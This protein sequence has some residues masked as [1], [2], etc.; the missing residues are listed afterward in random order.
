M[1]RSDEK[2]HLI[3]VVVQKKHG[4]RVLD[5]ASKAGATGA[6]FFPA[7]GTGI[8]QTMGTLGLLIEPEKQVI[9]IATAMDKTD[10]ILGA[11]AAAGELD[12]IGRG[13]AYVQEVV[14]TVGFTGVPK[15]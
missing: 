14:K 2:Q 10:A 15:A 3:T 13:F 9:L 6:T 7:Q 1:P 4:Y 5:A 8:R 11:V 12:Q